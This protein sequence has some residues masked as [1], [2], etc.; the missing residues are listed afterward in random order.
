[1]SFFC[2]E[3]RDCR[4]RRSRGRKQIFSSYFEILPRVS[5]ITKI[6]LIVIES[7]SQCGK[8]FFHI[9]LLI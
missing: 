8:D 9:K 1:V 7:G 6:E 5:D 2:A 3:P 4:P